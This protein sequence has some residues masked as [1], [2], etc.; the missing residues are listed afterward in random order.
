MKNVGAK[1]MQERAELRSWG[2]RGL[3][4]KGPGSRPTS[5]PP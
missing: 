2:P 4:G 5:S 1:V 3:A